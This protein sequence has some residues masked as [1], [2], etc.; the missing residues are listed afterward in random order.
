[1]GHIFHPL[2]ALLACST[3]QKLARQVAYLRE[4]NRILRARLPQWIITT[5][6]ER[7][8]LIRAGR[9]LGMQLKELITICSYNTFLRWL[10]AAGQLPAEVII[11]ANLPRDVDNSK[12]VLLPGRASR[13]HQVALSPVAWASLVGSF[14]FHARPSRA[15][16]RMTQ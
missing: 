12:H 5:P 10:P 3:R 6:R 2:L 1:M 16:V 8:R 15:S 11:L 13:P 9:K 4:E 7:R 14:K